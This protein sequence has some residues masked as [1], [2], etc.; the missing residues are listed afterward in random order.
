MSTPFF[1]IITATYNRASLLP[2]AI[3]SVLGQTFNDFEYIIVDDGSTDD[4]SAVVA[5][6]KDDRIRYVYQSN[7]ERSAARNNGLKLAKGRFICFID[8]DDE[9]LPGFLQSFYNYIEQHNFEKAFYYAGSIIDDGIQKLNSNIY[10]DKKQHPAVWAWHELL[11]NC[12]VCISRDFFELHQF[13]VQFN[14]WEDMHLWLRLLVQYPFY[15]LPDFLAIVHQHNDRSINNMFE[16]V[17]IAHIDKYAQSVN[18]LYNNYRSLISR[19]LTNEMR[20]DFLH[21]K[22]WIF[23]EIAVQKKFNAKA[24][25]LFKRT[26]R[27][28][29]SFLFNPK[30]IKVFL[31]MIKKTLF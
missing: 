16:S 19:H 7:S 11:L 24:F 5:S 21:D 8:S 4:T 13:P 30:F 10:S 20:R 22:Y 27:N 31:L 18:H 12:G 15:Q 3:R 2:V 17:D 9:Y 1:T 29:P 28:K 25:M 14:V 6:F 23:A 26:L